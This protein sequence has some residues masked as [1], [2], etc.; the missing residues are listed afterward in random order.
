MIEVNSKGA[1]ITYC[2]SHV[3]SITEVEILMRQLAPEGLCSPMN[4][5]AHT[6]ITMQVVILI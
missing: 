2:T 1:V 5:E 6:V 3:H 4:F